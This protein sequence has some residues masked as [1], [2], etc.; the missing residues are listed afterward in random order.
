[1]SWT[2]HWKRFEGW[3]TNLTIGAGPTGEQPTR[4][5]QNEFLHDAILG[6]P[7]VQTRRTRD[8]FDFMVDG[9]IT[10]WLPLL[11]QP[12]K[13]FVGVGGSTGSLYHEVFA[14]GSV[15]PRSAHQ[16]YHCSVGVR[17]TISQPIL[18]VVFDGLPWVG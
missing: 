6:I 17:R 12:K 8:E 4:Y 16:H 9:S 18:F 2:E 10:R 11:D 14:R 5:L 7:K 3:S 15:E 13:L 1:M